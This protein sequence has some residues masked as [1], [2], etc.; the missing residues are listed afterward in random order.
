M[1]CLYGIVWLCYVPSYL[2]P[3]PLGAALVRVWTRRSLQLGFWGVS[4]IV[5]TVMAAPAQ[6][7]RA[8]VPGEHDPRLKTRHMIYPVGAVNY[9]AERGFTGNVLVGF[10]WGSYLSWKLYPKVK[11]SLD[12][13]FEVAYPPEVEAEQYAFFSGEPGWQRLLDAEPYRATDVILAPRFLDVADSREAGGRPGLEARVPRQDVRAVRARNLASP[14]AR[15]PSHQ[16]RRHVSLSVS[17]A[18]R[19]ATSRSSAR[20]PR[21]RP[22]AGPRD[23]RRAA[24]DR[25]ADRHAHARAERD[26][27]QVE[28]QQA[29]RLVDRDSHDRA[30]RAPPR[31]ARAR[32]RA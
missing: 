12:S 32:P 21:A 31:A 14:V 1:L 16:P 23:P 24:R 29:P 15:P 10:D 7:W 3:T 28:A 22:R 9:L 27:H 25:R 4:L 17:V 20:S 13:R 11:V 6:P 2:A 26:R 5:F 30:R 19:R 18:A 8:R